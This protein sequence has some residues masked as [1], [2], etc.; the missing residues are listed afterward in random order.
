MYY[1]IIFVKFIK[2]IN[3][4]H[5]ENLGSSII[6]LYQRGSKIGCKQL[7]LILLG[8]M[9]AIRGKWNW[10][11]QFWPTSFV[12]KE[13]FNKGFRNYGR[14]LATSFL[15]ISG[16]MRIQA[17]CSSI[18]LIYRMILKKSKVTSIPDYEGIEMLENRIRKRML[19]YNRVF[20]IE[21]AYISLNLRNQ[22]VCSLTRSVKKEI[23]YAR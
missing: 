7:S 21:S 4:N 13:G 16:Y 23:Y 5:L 17:T 10:Q 1:I 8:L 11:N 20:N 9:Q 18:S 12:L 19:E 15:H 6:N 22:A 3:T 2:L 14:T